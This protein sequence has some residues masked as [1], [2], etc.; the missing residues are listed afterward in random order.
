HEGASTVAPNKSTLSTPPASSVK[1]AGNVLTKVIE[2][3]ATNART[4]SRMAEPTTQPSGRSA[5]HAVPLNTPHGNATNAT[6]EPSLNAISTTKS[7]NARTKKP[8]IT[9]N[10]ARKIV[11]IAKKS[12]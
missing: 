3:E 1:V 10:A 6:R 8:S 11:I 5:T 2:T 7:C 9:K 12:V 4:K